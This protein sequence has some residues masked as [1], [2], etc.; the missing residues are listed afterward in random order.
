MSIIEFQGS[1]NSLVTL[2]FWGDIE[3]R[4]KPATKQIPNSLLT[5]VRNVKK[6]LERLRLTIVPEVGHMDRGAS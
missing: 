5:Q 2:G 1:P 6:M 4:T 3:R